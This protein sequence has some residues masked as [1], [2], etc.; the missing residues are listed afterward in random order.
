MP[1]QA[2]QQLS[3]FASSP[4]ALSPQT[5]GTFPIVSQAS[6][7]T[8]VF[9]DAAPTSPATATDF[10]EPA[11]VSPPGVAAP[12]S[13]RAA[14][15]FESQQREVTSPLQPSS[16]GGAFSPGAVAAS[17]FSPFPSAEPTSPLRPASRT[18]HL[19]ADH[20]GDNQSIRSGRSLTSTGSQG[21]R[22]PELN[23]TGL[24]S[25]IV[26]TISV[27]FQDGQ[28]CSS[29]LV[30]EIALA[31][32][33][34]DFSSP[35]GTDNIRL[36]NFSSLE[37]VA[38]NPA[39]IAPIP[40]KEGE[41]TLDLASIKKTQI[42]FKYQIHATEN[43]A[44][45]PLLISPAFKIEPMQ[46][47]IIVSYSLN[48]GFTLPAGRTSL[49]LSNV[50]LGLTLEGAKATSCLS[51][52]VGTFARDRNLIFWQLGDITLTLGA[53]PTKLLARFAT[54]SEAKSGA[55][56]ARWEVSGEHAAGLGSTLAVSVQ[57]AGGVSDGADPFADEDVGGASGAWKEVKG[58]RKMFAG[59]YVAK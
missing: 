25:S 20:T 37:K 54:E 57:H 1:P 7:S 36:E 41:Y 29:S 14:A 59:S 58:V 49:N 15:P 28:L 34:A 32:N 27:R 5:T 17:T 53:A 48:P 16:T 51:K 13:E 26:E 47:S 44:H 45:A 8:S 40:G 19:G 4:P 52:P 22:H 55:V 9:P 46:A 43:G 39:F 30:G 50:M 42:A 2:T 23:E 10:P 56:E 24:N 6:P 35:S 3:D 21:H 12:S 31:Y 18:A 38:P 11:P 33:A